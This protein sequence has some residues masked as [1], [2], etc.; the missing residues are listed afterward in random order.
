MFR[1]NF[2]QSMY[3]NNNMA[4]FAFYLKII[5]QCHFVLNVRPNNVHE[6]GNL[7]VAYYER[8]HTS[9]NPSIINFKTLKV[10]SLTST[11]NNLK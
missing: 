5:V 11:L 8:V 9:L 7:L 6:I 3:I 10:I 1:S 2:K 4:I